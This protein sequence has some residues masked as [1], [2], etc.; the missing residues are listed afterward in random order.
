MFWVDFTKYPPS[1]D[2]L[3]FTL[4]AAFLLLAGF[5]SRDNR[6]TRALVVFGGAPMFFYLLHLYTLLVLYRAGLALFGPN[7]G[8]RLGVDRVWWIWAVAALL[9]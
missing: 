9:V 4:G 8:E 3:L 7:H 5:E 2:F 1:L 6:A